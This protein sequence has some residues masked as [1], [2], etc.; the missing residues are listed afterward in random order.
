[1]LDFDLPLVFVL[2]PEVP[3]ELVAVASAPEVPDPVPA[4][5]VGYV[6]ATIAWLVK[7]DMIGRH[8][9]LT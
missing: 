2:S 3:E 6:W 5:A 4:C 9:R 1:M 8:D 7:P